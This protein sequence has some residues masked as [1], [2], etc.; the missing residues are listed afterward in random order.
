VNKFI[1]LL[2]D[3]GFEAVTGKPTYM[4][5]Y[6]KIVDHKNSRISEVE[7]DL[8][9]VLPPEHFEQ[10][11]LHAICTEVDKYFVGK[12]R[13]VHCTQPLPAAK[14]YFFSHYAYFREVVQRQPA[15]TQGNI[16]LFYTHP[17]DLWFSRDELF[18]LF[19]YA[20]NIICMCSMFAADLKMKKVSNVTVALTGADNNFFQFHDRGTGI[21]GFCSA[22]YPRKN[23]DTL[24]QIIQLMPEIKFKLCGRNWK[25][26][27]NWN[28]LRNLPNFEYLEIDYSGYAEFYS[29]LDVLVSVSTLEGGPIPLIE[30]MMSNV[31]PVASNM[32]HA[33]DI[34]EHGENGFLFDV[35]SPVTEIC[36]LITQAME[37][38]GNI[39]TTVKHLTWERF[40]R[41][42]Q[43]IAF[44]QVTN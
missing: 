23:G 25:N 29:S 16:L 37:H 17:R 38:K 14:A 3:K 28:E 39:R 13:M 12:S 6:R 2:L 22:Y 5:G 1:S 33:P 18:H 32:G 35:D 44:S 40:S 21:V 20:N 30:A 7:Y 19:G 11:I 34:I 42:V 9:Y 36:D 27:E 4:R 10:W 41:Q 43:Q 8:V 26:W 24:L 31:V 15:V